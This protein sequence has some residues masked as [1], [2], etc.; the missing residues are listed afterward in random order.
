[1]L[2]GYEKRAARY[3]SSVMKC[4]LHANARQTFVSSGKKNCLKSFWGENVFDNAV[5]AAQAS[6]K[7]LHY[8]TKT[9]AKCVTRC[10]LVLEIVL[11][12][13]AILFELRRYTH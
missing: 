13:K 2:R 10:L 9:V 11:R 7:W 5:G 8:L 1:M 4:F 3:C 12:I 6:G